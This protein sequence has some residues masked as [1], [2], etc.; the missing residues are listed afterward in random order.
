MKIAIS[1]DAA[2]VLGRLPANVADLIRA[3]IG[4][5]AKDP[6]ALAN[7]VK[8]LKGR[9][10]YRLRVGDWRVIFERTRDTMIVVAIGPR[11]GIYDE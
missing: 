2:K 8:K 7:N 9:H 5:Y 6:K 10:A 3:K 1:K 11:S 4:R